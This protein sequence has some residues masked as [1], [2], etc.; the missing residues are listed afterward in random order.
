[1]R[2]A[3]PVWKGRV[4]PVFD[5]AAQVL[6][7]EIEQGCE[8]KRREEALSEHRPAER[9]RRLVELGVD[10]LICGAVSRPLATLLAAAGVRV[11]PWTAGPIEGVLNAYLAGK[12]PHPQWLMPGCSCGRHEPRGPGRWR[13]GGRPEQSCPRRRP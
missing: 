4:S 2:L 6:L 9:V 5:A 1:M 8:Q 7:V 10:V 3:I 13:Q 12:L 11:V